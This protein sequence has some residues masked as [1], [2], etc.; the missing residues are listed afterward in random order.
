MEDNMKKFIPILLM[1][2]L[3]H[4]NAE[5]QAKK[6]IIDPEADYLNTSEEIGLDWGIR[7]T[8]EI[9]R[10]DLD[11]DGSGRIVTFLHFSRMGSK[12]GPTWTAYIP[13]NGEFI[14]NDGLQ[15]R[16][17][18]FRAGK[19]PDLN[20]NGG[21]LFYYPGKGGGT[22]GRSQLMGDHFESQDICT[23]NFENLDD[24]KLYER[25]FGRKF[26]D[27]I[28]ADYFKNPPHK[29][30][31]TQDVMA[32]VQASHTQGESPE[33]ASKDAVSK[34]PMAD[35]TLPSSKTPEV[36]PSA[37]SKGQPESISRVIWAMVIVMVAGL[38]WLVLKNRK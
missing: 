8:D 2:L 23:L 32:R 16:E 36:K 18:A 38:F 11:V 22:L 28:P 21:V 9:F 1:I 15:F 14:R 33:K 12:G 30:I 3:G 34:V 26:D 19:V 17:D 20:P 10:L 29:V 25:A 5:D 4:A 6:H 27:S 37:V 31:K 35:P 13:S 24:Q 7:Q